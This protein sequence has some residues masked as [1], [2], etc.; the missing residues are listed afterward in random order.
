M[1]NIALIG[2]KGCGKGRMLQR[3]VQNIWVESDDFLAA[4]EEQEA[5]EEEAH[6]AREQGLMLVM[7]TFSSLL[8][9]LPRV[10]TLSLVFVLDIPIFSRLSS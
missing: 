3:L 9:R 4:Y 5:Q 8:S 7:K 1:A 10:S 6:R 2:R